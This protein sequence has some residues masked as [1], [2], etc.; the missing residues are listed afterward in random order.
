MEKLLTLILP[1][2]LFERATG[3]RWG[4]WYAFI[5]EQMLFCFKGPFVKNHS[6]SPLFF[7]FAFSPPHWKHGVWI[8]LLRTFCH[9][10]MPNRYVLLNLCARNG[11]EWRLM[12]CYGRN[13]SREWSG[14]ILCGEAWQNEEGGEPFNLL[15]NQRVL[16]PSRLA[17]GR[18]L[19]TVNQS[20]TTYYSDFTDLQLKIENSCSCTQ[21]FFFWPV[22]HK[23]TSQCVNIAWQKII[24]H[25]PAILFL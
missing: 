20:L 22:T 11:T 19:G 1:K 23:M 14:Q 9:T 3:L 8:I 24:E 4:Q 21:Q 13:S 10:W 12:A 7:L 2:P 6:L 17:T 16:G 25:W 15:N 5:T 18:L